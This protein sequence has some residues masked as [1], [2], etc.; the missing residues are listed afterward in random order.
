[1]LYKIGFPAYSNVIVGIGLTITTIVFQATIM[2]EQTDFTFRNYWKLAILPSCLASAVAFVP[3]I[4]IR[5]IVGNHI[6][7]VLGFALLA[8]LWTCFAVF[9]MGMNKRERNSIIE[10]AKNKLHKNNK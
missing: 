8:A 2:K 10:F 7:V 1:M 4:G 9:F 3:M 5:L 6:A